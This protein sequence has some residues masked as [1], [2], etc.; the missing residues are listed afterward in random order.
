MRRKNN[1]LDYIKERKLLKHQLNQQFKNV[2]I[3]EWRADKRREARRS[4][5]L[6]ELFYV[7]MLINA[8]IMKLLF[9]YKRTNHKTALSTKLKEIEENRSQCLQT[10]IFQNVALDQSPL[11][12][13]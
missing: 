11:Q 4:K 9:K 12:A 2:T 5:M 8:F 10:F 7:F 6:K 13:T 1:E 3:E